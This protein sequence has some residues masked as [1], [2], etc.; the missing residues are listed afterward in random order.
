VSNDPLRRSFWRDI[1]VASVTLA[2]VGVAAYAGQGI[3]DASERE[4]AIPLARDAPAVALQVPAIIERPATGRPAASAPAPA[5]AIDTSTAHS[6]SFAEPDASAAPLAARTLVDAP[7]ARSASRA[8]AVAVPAIVA[9]PVEASPVVTTVEPLAAPIAPPAPAPDR[10]Q[11]MREELAACERE[12]GLSGVVCDQRT[13]LARCEG[14]WGRVS[15]CPLP[16]ENPG[17]Q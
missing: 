13:R 15:A 4:A 17:G 3:L 8:D 1:A 12:G 11:L 10:W 6:T 9:P 14:Y 5:P 2:L 16:P 7:R